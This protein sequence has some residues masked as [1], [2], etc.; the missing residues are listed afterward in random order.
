MHHK[1]KTALEIAAKLASVNGPLDRRVH[2]VILI[3]LSSMKK[4]SS[5]TAV[6]SVYYCIYSMQPK[7][8]P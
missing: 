1:R 7:F 6:Y 2:V 8:I 3:E 4:V 5:V